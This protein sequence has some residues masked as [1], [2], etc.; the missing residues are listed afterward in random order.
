MPVTRS[1][2]VMMFASAALGAV[3]PRLTLDLVFPTAL[4]ELQSAVGGAIAERTVL[5]EMAPFF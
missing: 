4:A 5:V 2:K 1:N 3:M